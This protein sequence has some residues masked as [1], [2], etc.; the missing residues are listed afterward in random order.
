VRDARLE[1]INAYFTRQGWNYIAD[2]KISADGLELFF[3]AGHARFAG[4]FDLYVVTRESTVHD[5]EPQSI[6]RLDEI[7]PAGID[8][9]GPSLSADGMTLLW[10]GVDSPWANGVSNDIWMATR[11]DRTSPFENV[12]NLGF[13]VNTGMY[14]GAC[15]LSSAWPA[16][17]SE[18]YFTQFT[19]DLL[20]GN[21]L[22]ATWHLDCN[23]NGVDDTEDI[24]SGFSDDVNE[25]GI[26]DECEPPDPPGQFRRGN[27]NADTA[28]DIADAVFVLAYLFASGPAPSCKNAADANDDG[29]LDL[30]DAVAVLAHLFAGGAMSQPLD[31][32]GPD[33]TP[34]D[35]DCASFA[36]CN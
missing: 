27:A 20:S 34:D 18:L 26:P 17:G 25:N 10:S 19:T 7:W 15:S 21:I 32:C 5:F 24:R 12:Q 23:D 6:R 4:Q 1:A 33:P 30:A 29:K 28:L 16:S 36:P 31:Q 11:P 35:L 14:E 8:E 13:P 9:W 2:P 22:V 3:S